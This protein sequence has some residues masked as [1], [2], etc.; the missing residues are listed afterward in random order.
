VN[1]SPSPTLLRRRE[2]DLVKAQVVAPLNDRTGSSS[3]LGALVA[4]DRTRRLGV[5]SI[6]ELDSEDF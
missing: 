4:N 1:F 6:S 2:S 5:V 3:A